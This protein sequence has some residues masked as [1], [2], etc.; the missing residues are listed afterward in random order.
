M[1]RFKGAT[2]DSMFLTIVKFVTMLTVIVQTKILSVGLSLTNYGTYSQAMVVVSLSTSILLLGLGDAIN[3]FYNNS[4]SENTIEKKK[5]IIATVFFIEMLAG[6]ILATSL[7]LCRHGIAMYFS[8]PELA[9]VVLIIAI[10]PMLD[11]MIY[12]YQVLFVS[13]G[14]AKV[15]AIRNLVVSICK[16]L[17]ITIAV[18]IFS[19][20]RI[21]FLFI[22]LLNVLQ[23]IVFFV[24]FSKDGFF[25]NPFKA[26]LKYVKPILLYG[27]PMGIFTITTALTRDIDKLIIGYMSDTETVA[28]YSNCSRLLP[29]DII[30]A[31]FAT[32][33]MPYIMKYISANKNSISI[34]LFK[35]YLCIGYYSVWTLG[36]AILL[37][38]N[39]AI[40]FLYSPIYLQGKSIFVIYIIDSMVKFAS[41]HLILT[42]SGNSKYLMKCSM[43]SLTAN[44]VLNIGLYKLI[45]VSGPA[46]A[47]LIVTIVYTFVVLSKSKNIL[48][49]KWK[50]IFNFKEITIFLIGLVSVG[51]I[52]FA[53][54]QFLLKKGMQIYVAMMITMFGFGIVILILYL[55]KIKNVLM[56]I[57]RM[58]L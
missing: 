11:N 29:L 34:N 5:R 40:C 53:F 36:T 45:G 17:A 56:S 28:I 3:F 14:K 43:V 32:V 10:Q 18:M 31:S 46:L 39:Q 50:E 15:I 57:N 19:S 52:F 30:V 1:S 55:G 27:I 21:I 9:V 8:N 51:V 13:S 37:V 12:F 42:A 33:L 58:K 48:G 35:N 49:A 2:W 41:M 54:N 23:L 16:L 38:T 20:V 24:F 7:I 44:L 25:I 22:I 4:S 47:T 6:G 26:D